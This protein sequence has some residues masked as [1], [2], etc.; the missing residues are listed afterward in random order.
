MKKTASLLLC[1]CLIMCIV[2]P[3][4]SQE[5]DYYSVEAISDYCEIWNEYYLNKRIDVKYT[6]NTDDNGQLSCINSLYNDENQDAGFQSLLIPS[7]AAI[8]FAY[9]PIH[10]FFGISIFSGNMEDDLQKVRIDA[11]DTELLPPDV[12]S[13]HNREDS[14]NFPLTGD[15]MIKLFGMDS[16]SIVLITDRNEEEIII[17]KRKNR[18]F[19][20]MV[21]HLFKCSWY[22]REDN[23]FYLS[24]DY[25]PDGMKNRGKEKKEDTSFIKD[26]QG[27]NRA[28][29]SVFYVEAYDNLGNGLKS[30]SGFVAFDEHLFITNQHVIEDASYLLIL[31][32]QQINTYKLDTVIASDRAKDIAIL[33]FSEG[34][35]YQPLELGSQNGLLR[36][37][38]V[39]TIGSPKGFPGTVSEGI[40]SGFPDLYGFKHIQITAPISHGSSG[41]CLFDDSGKVI[42]VTSGGEEE[43]ENIGWA[44]P[45]DY[46]IELY[47]NWNKTDVEKLGT[48]RSWEAL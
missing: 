25:L 5:I 22:A 39:V 13:N 46:V 35:D 16:F 20:D 41:G 9:F 11:I 44:I 21:E 8:L 7:N 48:N 45:I 27:I 26:L 2:T 37:Q 36:G 34:K 15:E 29:Q 23:D 19:Y 30:A 42:G 14:W 1:I 32:D 17:S 10:N 18:Y 12:Y 24:K 4:V 31:D 47:N 38:P 3:V 40:I 6:Y 28:A 43:G 33:S